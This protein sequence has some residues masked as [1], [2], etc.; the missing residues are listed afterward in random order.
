[1]DECQHIDHWELENRHKAMNGRTALYA[2]SFDPMTL[3]HIDVVRQALLVFDYVH[4]GIGRNPKKTRLFSTDESII[5][6]KQS[7]IEQGMDE[8][9]CRYLQYDGSLMEISREIKPC[10]IVRGLR[11][12]SDFNDEFM[13]N[14]VCANTIPHIPIT[15][16]ICDSRYLHVSSSTAKELAQHGEEVSWM[17]SSCVANRLYEISESI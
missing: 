16:F 6:I 12:A 2:G 7:L 11:Q 10:A 13:I 4:I 1:M 9:R 5:L 17:V 15:Y 8:Q 14:G 3:G